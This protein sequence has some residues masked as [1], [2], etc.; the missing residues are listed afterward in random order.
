MSAPPLLAVLSFHRDERRCASCGETRLVYPCGAVPGNLVRDRCKPCALAIAAREGLTV[1]AKS[2]W[3]R[4]R[5]VW[6]ND[7]L[8][9]PDPRKQ[10][11]L[12]AV[13]ARKR[14]NAPGV[15]L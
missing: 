4:L 10:Q 1:F 13:R 15:A 7:R 5:A 2:T 9:A 14:T 8:P 3:P 11:Q 12:A 6:E